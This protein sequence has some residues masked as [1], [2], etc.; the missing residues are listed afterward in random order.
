MTKAVSNFVP[1]LRFYD[2]MELSLT[3]LL[4]SRI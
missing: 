3:T 2:P 4:L 1:H